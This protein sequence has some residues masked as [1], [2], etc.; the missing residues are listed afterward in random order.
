M[1]TSSM[2]LKSLLLISV[3]DWEATILRPSTRSYPADQASTYLGN[4]EASITVSFCP[5]DIASDADGV[6]G[7]VS[8]LI[9]LGAAM[10][11]GRRV[12][13]EDDDDRSQD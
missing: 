6:P 12:L 8:A 3:M 7:F 4:N 5:I 1:E 13:T 9:A 11:A 10:F 2:R